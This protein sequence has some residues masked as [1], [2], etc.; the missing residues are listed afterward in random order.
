MVPGLY[1]HHST[2]PQSALGSLNH[3]PRPSHSSHGCRAHAQLNVLGEDE[4]D[5]IF[6]AGFTFELLIRDLS[7]TVLM[8]LIA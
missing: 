6:P 8:I 4:F 1:F 3:V 5:F 2:W 7:G